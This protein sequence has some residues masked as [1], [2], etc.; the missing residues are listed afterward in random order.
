MTTSRVLLFPLVEAVVPLTVTP[1]I[2][3]SGM[4]VPLGNVNVIVEE[5]CV[6]YP[7]SPNVN[8][9]VYFADLFSTEGLGVTAGLLIVVVV[10]FI[11]K[12]LEVELVVSWLV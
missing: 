6:R 7:P 3:P 12:L 8:D 4:V 11:V 2:E 9:M 1:A 10:A 5:F